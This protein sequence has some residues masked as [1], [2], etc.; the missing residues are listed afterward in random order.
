MYLRIGEIEAPTGGANN[1]ALFGVPEMMEIEKNERLKV[2]KE[3][4]G[5]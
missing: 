5:V 4:E 2:K 3:Y 1:E